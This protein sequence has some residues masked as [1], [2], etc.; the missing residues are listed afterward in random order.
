M[1][2][3]SVPACCCRLRAQLKTSRG[4][5]LGFPEASPVG[6]VPCICP[7]GPIRPW[8][9]GLLLWD[10][11]C[12]VKGWL[13]L[14]PGSTSVIFVSGMGK[15]VGNLLLENSQLLETK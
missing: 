13:A 9:G 7:P 12:R 8:G 14:D 11:W 2:W 4:L 15:E 5:S 6:L 1:L 10:K 3:D